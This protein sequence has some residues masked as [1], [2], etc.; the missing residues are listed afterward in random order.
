VEKQ[1]KF[2]RLSALLYKV[3]R[4][5]FWVFLIATVVSLAGSVIMA[6]MP[7]DYFNAGNTKPIL[8]FMDSV[9]RYRLEPPHTVGSLKPIFVT[10][11]LSSIAAFGILALIFIKLAGILKSVTKDQPFAPENAGRLQA[12]GVTLLI[13]SALVNALR[14]VV[15]RTMVST[16]N[17]E[18]IN[19]NFSLNTSMLLTGLLVLI[20]AGVFRYGNY[21][22]EEV[23]STL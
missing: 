13:A 18:A 11:I 14:A 3:V 23:D 1:A 16:L 15:I 9:I 8:L 2:K 5:F 7:A 6:F 19:V 10:A 22:Q 4:I 21:L 20:L 17:I 12:I